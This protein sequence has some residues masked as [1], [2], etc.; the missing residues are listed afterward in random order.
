MSRRGF[1]LVELLVVIA[2]VGI[3]LALLLPAVQAARESARRGQCKNHL[4]HLGL[5]FLAHEQAH[6]VFPSCGWGGAWVG[7]PDRGTGRSQS[8]GWAYQT[9]PYLEQQAL[10]DIG[11]GLSGNSHGP[12]TSLLF[13]GS[14]SIATSTPFPL[15]MDRAAGRPSPA[16]GSDGEYRSGCQLTSMD[17]VTSLREAIFATNTVPG[18]DENVFDFG[19]D[20]PATILLEHGELDQTLRSESGARLGSHATLREDHFDWISHRARWGQPPAWQ[21]T[22]EIADHSFRDQSSKVNDGRFYR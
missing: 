8:G 14:S 9:L 4:K 19:H 20:G 11:L 13:K 22:G 18:A 7:V 6:G 2:I 12:I 15:P 16:G 5:A 10:F 21:G 3:L 17:D 1:T